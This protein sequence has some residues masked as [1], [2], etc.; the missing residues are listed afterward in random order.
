MTTEVVTR[1][2][3][4]FL[5]MRVEIFLEPNSYFDEQVTQRRIT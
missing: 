1:Q 5:V 2:V 4:A 3:S